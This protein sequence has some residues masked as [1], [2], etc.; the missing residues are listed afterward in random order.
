M[1][2][3]SI[4]RYNNN[5]YYYYYYY[6]YLVREM[7]TGASISIRHNYNYKYK[8]VSKTQIKMTLFNFLNLLNK[9]KGYELFHYY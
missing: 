9:Q 4:L 1:T 6:Y 2:I 7:Y 3:S 8:Y 5:Y